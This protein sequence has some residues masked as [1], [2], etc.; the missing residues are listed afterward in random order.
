MKTRV[1]LQTKKWLAVVFLIW[2][3][4]SACAGHPE[5]RDLDPHAGHPSLNIWLE[6]SLIPYLQQQ[7]TQ[8]P[9]FKGQPVLLVRMQGENVLPQIDDLTEQTRQKIVDALLKKPGLHLSWRPTVKPWKH[10]QTLEEIACGEY[11]DVAYYIGIDAGL[12]PLNR[13]LYVKVRAL[14]LAEHIWVAGFGKSWSGTPTQDQLDALA[15]EHPDEYLRG[16][17][18]LPF[19]EG[20][21]DLLAA[22]LARNLSC[23][24]RQGEA[25]NLVVHVAAPGPNTPRVI[26]IALELVGRYLTRFREV[27]VTDD[28]NQANITVVSAIHPIDRELL[29]VGISAKRRQ[30][31]IYLPGAETEAYLLVKSKTHAVIA[32]VNQAKPAIPIRPF[33]SLSKPSQIIS[34]FDILTPLN[35]RLCTTNM[36]W[37]SGVQRVAAYDLLPA[38][39]CMAVEMGISYPAYVFLI[40]QNAMG[41]LS[42]IFPSNCPAPGPGDG[43]L[44]PGELFRFPPLSD[45]QSAV[46]ELD[47]SPGTERIFAIAITAPQL[48]AIFADRLKELQDL[49]RPGRKYPGTLRN[50]RRQQ[51]HERIQRWQNYLTWLSINN[52]GL[53]EWREFSFQ[54]AAL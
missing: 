36:P 52:P 34:T 11:S 10:Q 53:I 31:E 35:Q 28:P 37:S 40:G 24:L 45:P 20:Q 7:F 30:G 41:E 46:L 3:G 22:Y 4:L 8:H 49:C 9:R 32:D 44:H 42:R 15:R 25:D 5:S 26:K 50:D 47:G 51:P 13:K 17:R 27:E 21:P 43:L 6:N 1:T 14:N 12:S 54:H 2:L 29:Q 33:E 19:T 38:G 39:S 18:P 23:L 48:A 16:L